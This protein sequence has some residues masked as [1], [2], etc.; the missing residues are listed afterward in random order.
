MDIMGANNTRGETAGTLATVDT[1]FTEG[2]PA[3]AG[4]ENQQKR[5]Q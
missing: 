1:A 5:Q 3:T 4:R 2:A